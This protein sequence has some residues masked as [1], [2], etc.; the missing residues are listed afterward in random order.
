MKKMKV[1]IS[2]AAVAMAAIF[3]VSAAAPAKKAGPALT[4]VEIP[5]KAFKMS[6]TEVTQS[7]Y[8]KIMGGNHFGSHE[9]PNYPACGVSWYD[10]IYFC[11][12]LSTKENLEPVYAV[13]NE[14]DVSKWNYIPHK[15]NRISGDITVN[16]MANGYRLPTA[17]E[18]IYAANGGQNF[19]YAGSDKLD[20]VAVYAYNPE[21]VAS[22]KPNGYGLY[23]MSGN[24]WEWCW[25][26]VK[27]N[28]GDNPPRLR[29][30]Y[31]GSYQSGADMNLYSGA[32]MD[33]YSNDFTFGFRVVCLDK[34]KAIFGQG[35]K[36][37][38]MVD[39]PDQNFK[40]SSTE[41]T[42]DFYYDVMGNNPSV[43]K[44]L[45]ELLPVENVS[46][47]D[48]VAFCNKLSVLKGLTPVYSVNGETDIT[49][50]EWVKEQ[51]YGEEA[52]EY[53]NGEIIADQTASGFRLPTIEEWKYAAKGGEDFRYA[54]S[55][56]LNEVAWYKEN[57]DGKPHA[58]A[59][60]KPNKYGLYDMTGNVCEWCW[61][62]KEIRWNVNG[63]CSVDRGYNYYSFD[64]KWYPSIEEAT[65]DDAGDP[66]CK[67]SVLGFRVVA[68]KTE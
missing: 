35:Q 17:G 4:M 30:L 67:S 56:D 8:E 20:E 52:K 14:K 57:S 31:G 19:R 34:S 9:N 47:F 46:W 13:A 50:W 49:K 51:Y 12:K 23:D 22:K 38:K 24:V 28:Y 40:M 48:A 54:G 36:E 32:A 3:S 37:F 10:A 55:D 5:G 60:K 65:R 25:D 15:G 39:I 21:K 62:L 58:V 2:V 68:A 16:E 33:A 7:V 45:T 29:Y 26:S 44:S 66:K 53:V 63:R 11:N 1:M 59:Q 27:D 42:Q 18:W 64:E 61:D 41:I 6:K 43:N